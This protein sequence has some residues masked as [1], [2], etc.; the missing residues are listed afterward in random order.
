MPR[1]QQ[2]EDPDST[3]TG[4]DGLLHLRFIETLR[5]PTPAALVDP[6][7][8]A[9][10][11]WRGLRPRR[12]RTPSNVVWI[13]LAIGCR[14]R[15]AH[16]DPPRGRSTSSS[17]VRRR[18]L[19]IGHWAADIADHRPLRTDGEPIQSFDVNNPA[20]PSLGPRRALGPGGDGGNGGSM[21][22]WTEPYHDPATY[23]AT[24]AMPVACRSVSAEF[25][26]TGPTSGSVPLPMTWLAWRR[27]GHGRDPLRDPNTRG[28]SQCPAPPAAAVAGARTA[29]TDGSPPTPHSPREVSRPD[30]FRF[31][32]GLA[33]LGVKAGGRRSL[34][35][36][37]SDY[38]NKQAG[39]AIFQ[40]AAVRAG[41][42]GGGE[43]VQPGV[44]L[45]GPPSS[46]RSWREQRLQSIDLAGNGEPA[47]AVAR[48][49]WPTPSPPS[50]ESAS[51]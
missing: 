7:S 49:S 32:G 43:S 42:G 36:V 34:A 29:G 26:R 16:S 3:G 5:I 25:G 50:R 6:A 14:H 12:S 37:S 39:P 13:G 33:L 20:A 38:A 4:A 41:T 51:T 9:H 35:V 28:L 48:S 19:R 8:G 2:T 15:S 44:R 17:G 22:F 24:P 11:G 27:P 23:L 21:V 40:G 45:P 10:L 30:G 47:P 18:A 31:G 46:G 1:P